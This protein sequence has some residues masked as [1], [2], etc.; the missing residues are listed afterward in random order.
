MK[1]IAPSGAT[2]AASLIEVYD[3]YAALVESSD[4]AIIAKDLDGQVIS[5]NP[6][7][8]RLFGYTSAE[9]CGHSI[10]ALLPDDRLEEEESILS[11]I[12]AGERV[13]QLQT[14]RRHKDGHLVDISVTVSPVRDA[15]GTIV[16]ASKIAR[17]IGPMLENQRRLRESE[18]RLR[19]LADNI[20][21]FAWI[22]DATGKVVW[23]NKRWMDYTGLDPSQ[24]PDER[25]AA[26]LPEEYRAPVRER[27]ELAVKTG[28]P[29]EDTFPLRG[30][31]G[32]LR[33]FLSRAQPI[34]DE[35]DDTVWWFGTNTDITSQREQEEQ[36][37]L[38]LLEVNHRSK[39]MLSTIQALARRSNR[40]EPGVMTRFEDRVRSLAVN[41][42]ILVQRQWREVPLRELVDGQ[43]QFAEGAAGQIELDGPDL[44]LRP[45]AAEVVGMALHELA[46]NSL[47]YGALS[48]PGGKVAIRWSRTKHGF[49]LCWRESGGPPVTPPQ[50]TGFGTRLICDVP[51]HNLSARVQL[52]YSRDGVAWTLECDEAQ[53][54]TA[55]A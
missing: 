54:V 30:K 15:G 46:T 16:G 4:D 24:M 36:I 44:S 12:R 6:A 9:M 14:R 33:W 22:A 42:D 7:A 52:T 39:N 23:F 20:A 32:E 17:N 40:D 55:E 18:A 29:W 37:R 25:R 49:C 2:G 31:D 27:F 48:C 5:W 38:L 11:R 19:M 1:G 10:R 21:Q 8:E 13:A 51:R 47:K 45:R 26:V 43:L 34:H 28:E 53:L 41:Q 35:H 3:F 50:R